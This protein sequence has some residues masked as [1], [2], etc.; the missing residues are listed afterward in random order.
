MVKQDVNVP[1]RI[2][3]LVNYSGISADTIR[4]YEKCGLLT[5]IRRTPSGMR[6]FSKSDISRLD[7]IRRAKLANWSLD[8]IRGL[9]EMRADPFHSKYVIQELTKRKLS[10]LERHIDGLCT[11]RQELKLFLQFGHRGIDGGCS[12]QKRGSSGLPVTPEIGN[13][14]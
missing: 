2:G 13:A 8:E 5:S 1:F 7:F 9:L 10:D 11:L 12:V 14:R 6:T 3:Q 4:Y